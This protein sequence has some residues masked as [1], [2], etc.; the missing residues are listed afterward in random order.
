ME[1]VSQ[2]KEAINRAWGQIKQEC[3]SVLGS[4]LHYQAMIYH[5][6]R[7][8]GSVPLE[9]IGMN[10]KMWIDNPVSVLFKSLDKR[11]HQDYQ[12]GFEPI[13]DIVLFSKAIKSD[14][15]RRNRNNTM[16]CMLAAV[17]VKA[18]ERAKSRL[19]PKEIRDDIL[20]L[21]AHRQEAQNLGSD[22]APIMMII[23]SAPDSSELMTEAAVN[24]SKDFASQI[25]VG[26]MYI[27]R[28]LEINSFHKGAD[29]G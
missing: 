26:F 10:V 7:A 13:P 21:A 28:K 2:A 20:K 6:L 16:N 11:K 25:N 23:D 8:S 9:Q 18:S 29:N 17:E 12:G 15:R 4:E 1:N 19:R 5:A 14:W 24:S 22:F 27:S 3:L